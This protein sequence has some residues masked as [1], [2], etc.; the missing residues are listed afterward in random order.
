LPLPSPPDDADAAT[1]ARWFASLSAT[2][3]GR[4]ERFCAKEHP[5]DPDAQCGGIGPLHIPTPPSLAKVR[6]PGEPSHDDWEAALTPQQRAY[7]HE[8]CDGTGEDNAFSALCGA[9]PLVVS[10]DG[11]P[12]AFV[13]DGGRFAFR[14][15][16]PVATD[17]PT[18]ATPWLALDRDGDGAITSGAELFGNATAMADGRAPANGFEALAVLDANHDGRLDADDPAFAQLVLWYDRDG[19]RRSTP[20]ELVPASTVIDAI[21]LDVA[22]VPRCTAD[23]DCERERAVVHWH[24]AT[25]VRH[26]GAVVDVYLR[27]RSVDAL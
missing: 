22:A 24:D 15:G 14:P 23:G 16:D 11:A 19:D 26:D 6:Q 4:I 9:T 27:Y 12:V 2:D 13:R 5:R 20:D 3:R 25:G 10:W 21:D 18:A 8:Q 7:Y 1:Y 17:W